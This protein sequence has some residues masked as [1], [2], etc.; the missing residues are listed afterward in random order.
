MPIAQSAHIIKNAEEPDGIGP[1][2]HAC[3][4]I[5]FPITFFCNVLLMV[6]LVYYDYLLRIY[7]VIRVT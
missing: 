7:K 6:V 5:N 1:W 3:Y 2:R 4:S